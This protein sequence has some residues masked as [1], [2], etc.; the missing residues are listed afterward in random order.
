MDFGFPEFSSIAVRRDEP[1]AM[2]D[3]FHHPSF[4]IHHPV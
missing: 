2:S 4:T 3:T 1:L